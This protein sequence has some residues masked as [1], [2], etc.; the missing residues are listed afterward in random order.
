MGGDPVAR[1]RDDGLGGP[2]R[3]RCRPSGAERRRC[4][5]P[6][7]AEPVAAARTVAARLP[8]RTIE[9]AT[10]RRS[11]G[12]DPVSDA[13]ITV[14]SAAG[15]PFG[16]HGSFYASS[17]DPRCV[18]RRAQ[19]RVLDRLRLV[20]PRCGG[21]QPVRPPARGCRPRAPGGGRRRPGLTGRPGIG[22]RPVQRYRVG[23]DHRAA[24]TA[25]LRGDHRHRGAGHRDAG[26]IEVRPYPCAC[27]R[28]SA[29]RRP[30]W[31]CGPFG[32]SVRARSVFT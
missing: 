24:V 4:P 8:W 26:L 30:R 17:R 25:D 1:D 7:T 20:P 11:S 23:T 22:H 27:G 2:R 19:R 16:G 28:G 3:W 9:P 14:A 15:G 32:E 5:A 21:V 6:P 13:V 10:G 29:G 18:F 12:D 31:S